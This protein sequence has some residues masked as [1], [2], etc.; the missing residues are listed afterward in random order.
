MVSERA[1]VVGQ[2][3]KDRVFSLSGFIQELSQ[4]ADVVVDVQTH[5]QKA[6]QV[7]EIARRVVELLLEFFLQSFVTAEYLSG[8]VAIL[9]RN[10]PRP[11]CGVQRDECEEGRIL[12]AGLL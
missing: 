6:D 9:I 8:S 3:N 2:E 4:L 12:C 11:V 7:F 1:A 5:R 10:E